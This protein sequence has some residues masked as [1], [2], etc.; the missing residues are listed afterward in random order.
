MSKQAIG[1][2]MVVEATAGYANST[3]NG[4]ECVVVHDS[5]ELV[6]TPEGW[7]GSNGVTVLLLSGSRAGREWDLL[8]EHLRPLA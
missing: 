4:S 7:R 6:W 5:G 8:R 2:L 3:L 1:G